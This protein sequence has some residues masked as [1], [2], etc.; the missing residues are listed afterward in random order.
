L[1]VPV[2]TGS[3]SA[4][5]DTPSGLARSSTVMAVGTVVSRAGFRFRPRF[6]WRGT[7]L[8]G[9]A[10][11]ARWTLLFVLANLVAVTVVTRFAT[12]ADTALPSGSVGTSAYLYA[13]TIWLLP[14]SVVTVS[15][16][17]AL[18]PRMSRAVAEQWLDD[19]RDDLSR[20]L[21]ISGLVTV[22]VAFFFLALGPQIAAMIP[23]GGPTVPMGRM[24]QA[25]ALGLIPFSAQYLLLRGFYAFSDTRT[26]FLMA[27]WISGLDIALA[28]GCHLLLPPRWAVTG[29]AA[30]YS[31]SYLA[32]LLLTATRLRRR[33]E[34]R[35]DGRR[36]VRTYGK[37]VLAAGAAAGAAW[38][39]ATYAV[40]V[41]LGP[42]AALPAG[43]AAM[44]LLF[45]VLARALRLPE[46]RLLPGLRT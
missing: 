18:L 46:L 6:D 39:V 24:L 32:G 4:R 20:G 12:S 40:P 1:D 25:F 5:R 14:Q 15:L 8:R 7:G 38:A 30:A 36:L 26:P 44:A 45:L 16:V 2:I 28:T 10:N 23:S 22:P 17:T 9:S 42:A 41:Q 27:V 29:M 43:G 19:V 33:L 35:L 37:L 13:Q 3:H 11:A 21:R 34:G 31:L